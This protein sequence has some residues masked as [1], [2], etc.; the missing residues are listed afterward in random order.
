MA[1]ALTEPSLDDKH[2][3]GKNRVWRFSGS[4][5]RKRPMNQLQSQQPHRKNQTCARKIA[6][7]VHYYGYRYYDPVTGRWPSRDPIEEE[8]GV[9]L[10]GFGPNNPINGL[11]ILGNE[12]VDDD[13]WLDPETGVVTDIC[14]LYTSP[15]PRD[16]G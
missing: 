10:Y 12:W 3:T 5:N 2:P 6:S 7:G 4:P 14:L 8:G 1:Y 16:R 9:N 13:L 15:S 11:D